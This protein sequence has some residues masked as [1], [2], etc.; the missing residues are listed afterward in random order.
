[1]DEI[2]TTHCAFSDESGYTKG[3][4]R[5]IGM[6]SMPI[7]EYKPLKEEFM[8]IVSS[9]GKSIKNFKWG[10]LKNKTMQSGISEVINL[11]LKKS[12]ENK[13]RIDVL[14][15]DIE[16]S[17][18]D[19]VH[20]DDVANLARMYFHVFKNV[21]ERR[22]ENE[23]I[24]DL[25]PDQNSAIN[26]D[27]LEDI[28]FNNGFHTLKDSK[29]F[30]GFEM[31]TKS[32]NIKESSTSS[33]P[34]IQLADIFAGM[35][36]YSWESYEKFEEWDIINNGQSL[37]FPPKEVVKISNTDKYRCP[38]LKQVSKTCKSKK[39]QL[40]FNSTKGFYSNN[41]NKPINFWLYKPQTEKDKAP[42]K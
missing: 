6:I 29:S 10:K 30:I 36:R 4:Y 35:G 21:L 1:M 18:H 42:T 22:W 40:S 24:W 41:P 39:L 32:V 5:S 27:L 23:S 2:K 34:L 31:F 9:H 26:W 12:I 8:E 28:L 3:R 37:L 14:T 33:T 11:A 38:I 13:I 19:I 20:R 7:N 25:F 16:D 15:W 17:S